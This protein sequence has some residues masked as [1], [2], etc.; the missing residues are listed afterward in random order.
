MSTIPLSKPYT[1]E[2][3]V[4][5]VALSTKVDGVPVKFTI[6]DAEDQ[7]HWV[8]VETVTRQGKPAPSV[9]MLVGE[10]ACNYKADQ[11]PLPVTFVGEVFQR[12]RMDAPFKDTSGIVR[13]QEDQSDKL[14]IA[15]FDT[16]VG[17]TGCIAG[18]NQYNRN[19]TFE[20]RLS[21]LLYIRQTVVHRYVM[22]IAQYTVHDLASLES[23]WSSHER[24]LPWAEGLVARSYSDPWCPGKRSWGYQKLLREPTIDLRIVD[25]EEGVGKNANAVGRLVAE[26]K[27]TRIGIGPGKLSY[28]EREYLWK[29]Y[30]AYGSICIPDPTDKEPLFIGDSYIAQIKYKRDEAYDAL[31]QPTFQTWRPDKDT[32]D[33]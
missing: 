28:K 18:N 17:L 13:R 12:G 24:G 26:Y 10:F 14:E 7:G 16:D 11:L 1:P 2:K 22:P 32:P 25:F 19:G 6:T 8:D 33:A 20:D 4:F 29:M 5:P 27:G 9:E 15:L 31:R 30:K 3:L 23:F 21:F